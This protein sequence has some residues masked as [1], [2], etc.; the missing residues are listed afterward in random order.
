MQYSRQIKG[1]TLI[2][3]MVVV[4]IVGI[5]AAIAYPSYVKYVEEG[6]RAEGKAAIATASQQL[7]RCFTASNTYDGCSVINKSETG[8]YTIAV[9]HP[10]SDKT[11]YVITATQTFGDSLCGNLTLSSEGEKKVVGKGTV[12]EC[13]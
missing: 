4:L 3:L 2:E 8:Y 12:G 11:R 13:W 6:K 10:G 5:L 9:S 1:F 7:E